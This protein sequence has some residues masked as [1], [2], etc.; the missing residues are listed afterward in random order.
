MTR[1]A[2]EIFHK[3]PQKYEIDFIIGIDDNPID[4]NN[5]MFYVRMESIRK[6]TGRHDKAREIWLSSEEMEKLSMLMSMASKFWKIHTL[7]KNT[8]HTREKIA[9]FIE[10]WERK[11][12]FVF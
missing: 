8:P 1:T 5:A 7:K 3:E 11:R 9:E 6:K 2:V 12:D 10:K 4:A